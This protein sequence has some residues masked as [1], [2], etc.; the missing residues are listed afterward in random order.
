MWCKS[1]GNEEQALGL[2]ITGFLLWFGTGAIRIFIRTASAAPGSKAGTS[3]NVQEIE[4]N[5]M[6]GAAFR[7]DKIAL[8]SIQ[9][10]KN[11]YAFMK[12]RPC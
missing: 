4:G 7:F 12:R 6:L 2:A 8:T 5:A 10:G 1:T 3:V 9:M 11:H